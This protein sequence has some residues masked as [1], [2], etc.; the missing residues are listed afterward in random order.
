MR[1]L[2]GTLI[3]LLTA[4]IW[5]SA[6]VAQSVAMDYIGPFTFNALRMALGGAALL[7]V[8]FIMKKASPHKDFGGKKKIISGGLICGAVL[9]FAGAAQNYALVFPDVTV[10]KAG[11]ITTLYVV[12]VPLLA[13]LFLKRKLKPLI[14]LSI[15][16][17]VSGLYLL[18]M[19]GRISFSRGELTL[20]VCSILFSVHI[21]AADHFLSFVDGVALSCAQFFSAALIS[22]IAAL[23]FDPSVSVAVIKDA[24][25]SILYAGLIS[26]G[27]AY[28]LQILG[29]K[30]VEPT[31]ASLLMSLESVF[32]VISGWVFL[33]EHLT[34][35]E[36]LG[37]LLMF[38]AVVL[39][40]LPEK[41]KN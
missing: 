16:L 13:A 17:A 9:A 28:T 4:M 3:L 40:E 11:F 34:L 25:I 22:A 37:C 1:R 39:S 23:I 24:Y 5:G 31:L 33:N 15:L 26:C 27:V 12:F 6:F 32:A 41:K 36:L 18:C 8:I 10:G 35:R 29:Q 20:L 14:I 38:A 21:L 7:P 19:T 2:K 30:Y